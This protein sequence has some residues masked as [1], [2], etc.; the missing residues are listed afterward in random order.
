MKIRHTMS[1]YK[2]YGLAYSIIIY[3]QNRCKYGYYIS[4]FSYHIFRSLVYR[5][6]ILSVYYLTYLQP[7]SSDSLMLISYSAMKT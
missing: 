3:F 7:P 5:S 4:Y 6:I 2:V 1:P